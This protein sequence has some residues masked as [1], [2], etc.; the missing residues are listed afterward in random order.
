[1]EALLPNPGHSF[2]LSS[3]IRSHCQCSSLSFYCS[4]K[5]FSDHIFLPL[6]IRIVLDSHPR[7]VFELTA[8]WVTAIS[9]LPFYPCTGT[10]CCSSSAPGQSSQ[11]WDPP[12]S[13]TYKTPA[14]SNSF[15]SDKLMN[16]QIAMVLPLF[17]PN[18]SKKTSAEKL[19]FPLQ[20]LWD[21][22]PTSYFSQLTFN[23]A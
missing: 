15:I 20:I 7:E 22:Q 6:T 5:P 9:S 8:I 12:L 19:H 2:S 10:K 17:E 21:N 13:Q 16:N 3:A 14:W 1:M 23:I 11:P 4:H 18:T